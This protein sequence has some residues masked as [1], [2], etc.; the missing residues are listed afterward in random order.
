MVVPVFLAFFMIAP[1]ALFASNH[2]FLQETQRSKFRYS[3]KLQQD[4]IKADIMI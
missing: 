1:E 3:F 2:A 4:I